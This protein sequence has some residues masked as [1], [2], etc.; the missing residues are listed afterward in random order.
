MVQNTLHVDLKKG[1]IHT[2][3]GGYVQSSWD[4]STAL[5]ENIFW[6]SRYPKGSEVMDEVI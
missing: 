1:C 6:L 4:A 3:T 2:S 5:T